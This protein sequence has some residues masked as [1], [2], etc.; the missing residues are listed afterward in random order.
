LVAE[1]TGNEPNLEPGQFGEDVMQL[2]VRLYAL[3]Y[4]RDLPDGVFDMRTENA[5]RA[6]QSALGQDNDG[7]VTQETWATIVELENRSQLE[8]QYQSP[9][10]A[11]TQIDYDQQHPEGRPGYTT[12]WYEPP[13]QESW[14]DNAAYEP[15]W[16]DN[17]AYE[18]NWQDNAAY[19]PQYVEGQLSEDG[20][21]QLRDGEWH[22]VG[23]GDATAA[24]TA[25]AS[26]EVGTISD[27]GFHRWNGTEWEVLTADSFIGDLSPDGYWRWDGRD[28]VPA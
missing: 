22:D 1:L 6:A 5:V 2:Q 20:R 19:E 3:G 18:P 4:Y 8:Y 16:Q 7:L 13:Y 12:N 26:I 11:R 21:W 24:E 9:Y 15:N 28:W 10:D 23:G 14:Q 25:P 27:S 17:A